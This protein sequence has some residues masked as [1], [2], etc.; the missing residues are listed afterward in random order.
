MNQAELLSLLLLASTNEVSHFVAAFAI[1]MAQRLH[2]GSSNWDGPRS[3]VCL[4][5]PFLASAVSIQ[6]RHKALSLE[7]EK[8]S[9]Y[10]LT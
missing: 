5:G 1:S 6:V 3:F 4:Q 7:T 2:S 8:F 9:W 10:S